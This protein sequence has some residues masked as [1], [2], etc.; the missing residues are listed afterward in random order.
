MPHEQV[1]DLLLFQAKCVS[2]DLATKYQPEFLKL[3][4]AYAVISARCRMKMRRAKTETLI[5]IYEAEV[6]QGLR[7]R[8]PSI[9]VDVP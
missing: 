4:D 9:M 8:V 1:I 3:I 2:Y 5:D 6:T 7:A